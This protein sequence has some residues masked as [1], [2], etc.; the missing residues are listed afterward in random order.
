MDVLAGDKGVALVKID[1]QIA[2]DEFAALSE[3]LVCSHTA[4]V[5]QSGSDSCE[6]L[7]CAKWLCNVVV[8]SHVKNVYLFPLLSAGGQNDYR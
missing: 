5:T 2:G 3:S 8:C 4:G 6:Q 7:A 1:R